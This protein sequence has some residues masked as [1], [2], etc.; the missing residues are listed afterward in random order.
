MFIPEVE[1]VELSLKMVRPFSLPSSFGLIFCF[2]FFLGF[3]WLFGV[4][5]KVGMILVYFLI[6]IE[7]SY[8]IF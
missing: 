7:L 5:L 1:M 4:Y 6:E 3:L 2:W 8:F